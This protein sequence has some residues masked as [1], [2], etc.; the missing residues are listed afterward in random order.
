MQTCCCCEQCSTKKGQAAR[1]PDFAAIFS[2]FS[3][4]RCSTPILFIQE[5]KYL[6]CHA[7]NH[8]ETQQLGLL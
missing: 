2:V 1:M 6:W 4:I 5:V 8:D 7:P 3:H